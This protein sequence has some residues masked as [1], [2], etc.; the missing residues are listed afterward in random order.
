MNFPKAI[1]NLCRQHNTLHLL[2]HHHI[3]TIN[4]IIQQSY[5]SEADKRK[6]CREKTVR[7]EK[8]G[9]LP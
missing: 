4:S 9:S 6:I 8:I 3:T 1:P 2:H 7:V 5:A